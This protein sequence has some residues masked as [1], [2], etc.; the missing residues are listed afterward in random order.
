MR[1]HADTVMRVCALYFR[2]QANRDDAFQ[3]TFVK[4]A[5][6]EKVFND[7]EHR[8][9]WL[10][11]VAT[12]TCKD[13]LKAA[14]MRNVGLD[15]CNEEDFADEGSLDEAEKSLQAA[16]LSAALRMLD[17]KYRD[18]LYLKYYEDYTTPQIADM[19]GIPENTVY[20]NIARGKQKL[21]EVLTHGERRESA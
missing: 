7:G 18:A 3:D 15:D 14:S 16:E 5:Q 4:Y 11:R 17:E 13:M 12:N 20:T 8:K 6:S 10:I 19:L 9:A 2:N 1:E 21:K